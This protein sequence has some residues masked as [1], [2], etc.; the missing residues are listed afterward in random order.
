MYVSGGVVS[1]P[2]RDGFTSS[3]ALW[4]HPSSRDTPNSIRPCDLESSFNLEVPVPVS[5]VKVCSQYLHPGLFP[6]PESQLALS[7][8]GVVPWFPSRDS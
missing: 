8:K 5:P 4:L 1:G 7:S 6:V 3:R 2:A